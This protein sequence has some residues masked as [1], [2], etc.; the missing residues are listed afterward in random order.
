[1]TKS[2]T[3]EI[4]VR[5]YDTDAQG[6]VHHGNYLKYF[7]TGRVELLRANGH[8]YLEI[9][10]SGLF[11]VV[12]KL[13][14]KYLRPAK[15]D[16]VLR[17]TTTVAKETRVS[18]EHT[19]ELYREKELL[20]TGATQVVCVNQEGKPQRIPAIIAALSEPKQPHKK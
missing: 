3:I 14:C 16:D 13:E 19:Y 12:T 6:V 18:I 9:E 15:F 11:L 1:M 5:Y 20:V 7:E 17:L 2:H 10:E 8:S 4:R